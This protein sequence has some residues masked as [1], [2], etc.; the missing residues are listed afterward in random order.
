MPIALPAGGG[1]LPFLQTFAPNGSG[2]AS[3]GHAANTC[4]V[5]RLRVS[6]QITLATAS[7]FNG[8]TVAGNIDAAILS[9]GALGNPADGANVALTLVASIGSTAASGANA[10]QSASLTSSA[11]LVPGIDYYIG[12]GA[13]DATHTWLLSVT[14]GTGKGAVAQPGAFQMG[15]SA[16]FPIASA[17]FPNTG[18]LI[19]PW[20]AFT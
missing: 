5:R 1:Q 12:G 17:T 7:W 8:A 19:L 13:S 4:Y 3:T 2:A 18:I 11:T 16:L 14:S 15:K 10:K 20:I 6:A 9:A